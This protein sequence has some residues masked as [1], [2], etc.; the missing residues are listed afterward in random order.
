[1][2]LKGNTVRTNFVRV[3]EDRDLQQPSKHRI[4]KSRKAVGTSICTSILSIPLP[5]CSSL[6][7]A[8]DCISSVQL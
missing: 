4:M 2:F 7:L 3:L 6:E 1:M 5:V 8:I